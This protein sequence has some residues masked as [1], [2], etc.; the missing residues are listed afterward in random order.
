[1]GTKRKPSI[2]FTCQRCGYP[3]MGPSNCT[4]CNVVICVNCTFVCDLCDGRFDEA[5]IASCGT[6]ECVTNACLNCSRR[7][8]CHKTYL[9]PD[10]IVP[11]DICKKNWCGNWHPT[12]HVR[13]IGILGFFSAALGCDFPIL[14]AIYFASKN[15]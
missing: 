12:Q 3:E 13:Q 15:Y 6:D 4:R 9:C 10:C 11:C 7:C 14:E 5:C 2:L 1:M 8:E